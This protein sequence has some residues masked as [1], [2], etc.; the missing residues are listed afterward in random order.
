MYRQWYNEILQEM[1]GSVR[2]NENETGQ[3]EIDIRSTGSSYAPYLTGD[4]RENIVRGR[5]LTLELG[6]HGFR[7]STGIGNTA[8]RYGSFAVEL[9]TDTNALVRAASDALRKICRRHRPLSRARY[10]F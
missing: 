1:M 10:R 5:F 9:S 8:P 4:T 3:W 2:A 7:C 6:L